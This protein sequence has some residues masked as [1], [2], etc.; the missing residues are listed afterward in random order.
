MLIRPK[1]SNPLYT[2]HESTVHKPRLH[3]SSN[4]TE[5]RDVTNNI[6][7]INPSGIC[8]T[9]Y[10]S[11]RGFYLAKSLLVNIRWKCFR[12]VQSDRRVD[13]KLWSGCDRSAGTIAPPTLAR[14]IKTRQKYKYPAPDQTDFNFRWYTYQFIF[15]NPIKIIFYQLFEN[16]NINLS[17]FF[18]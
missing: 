10:K 15:K 8:I 6:S 7:E 13:T 18:F 16:V 4:R 5:L 11:A 2:L 3:L 17:E 1:L 14:P 9:L 12:R